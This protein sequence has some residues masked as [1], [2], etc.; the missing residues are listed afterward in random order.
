MKRFAP[1][2]L[3]LLLSAVPAAAEDKCATLEACQ[4]RVAALEA[5]V[6]DQGGQLAGK[7]AV[8]A[9]IYKQRNDALDALAR[10]AGEAAV[11]A[12]KADKK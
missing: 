11:A 5:A 4:A 6:A 9:T 10:A 12:A 7:D 3:A 2:S 1:L 8:I